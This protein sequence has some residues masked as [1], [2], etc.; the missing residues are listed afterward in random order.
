MGVFR[1]LIETAETAETMGRGQYQPLITEELELPE[2]AIYNSQP[3]A[4]PRTLI[5]ILD[6]TVKAHPQHPVIDNEQTRLTYGELQAEIASRAATMRA[7]GIGK[8]DHVGIRMTSG[9]VDLYVSI[10]AVLT[11]GAAYV[12]VDVDDPDERANTVWTE[13]GVCAVLTDGP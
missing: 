10:L 7:A 11:A 8:G 9:T 13:A 5:D 4:P 2:C 6:E 12:P 1:F 3:T